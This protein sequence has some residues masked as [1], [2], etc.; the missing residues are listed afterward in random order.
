MDLHIRGVNAVADGVR[1][2][3]GQEIV[4]QV[5]E[6]M[7]E[8]YGKDDIKKHIQH[9]FFS[10]IFLFFNYLLSIFKSFFNYS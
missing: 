3:G 10:F 2:A 5:A 7:P 4:M 9:I 1:D 8:K 6:V